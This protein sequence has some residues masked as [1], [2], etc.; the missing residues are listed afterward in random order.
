MKWKKK[1]D[2][3]KEQNIQELLD[4]G[5]NIHII[6]IPKGKEGDNGGEEI[7]KVITSQELSKIND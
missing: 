7:L 6:G 5:C 2:F 1:K 3:K 4:K